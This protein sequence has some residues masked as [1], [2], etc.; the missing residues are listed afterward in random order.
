M[1]KKNVMHIEKL[2]LIESIAFLP[3]SL[4]SS[5]SLLKLPKIEEGK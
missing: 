5:S 3:F 2:L 4:L 1:C